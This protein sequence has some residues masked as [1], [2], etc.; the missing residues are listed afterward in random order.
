MEN[1]NFKEHTKESVINTF[2]IKGKKSPSHRLK[3]LLYKFNI[4]EQVCECCGIE[5]IWN[6][7]P[8]SFHLDHIDG[9][10]LNNEVI[11]LRILCPN[12]HSQTDT[13]AGKKNKKTK[14][15]KLIELDRHCPQCDSLITRRA[16]LCNSCSGTKK[17][18]EKRSFVLPTKEELIQMLKDTNFVQV[19]KKYNVS[20]N[21]VKKWCIKYSISSYSK[22]YK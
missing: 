15:Q 19:G 2:L 18:E 8:I 21:A 9:D 17:A 10:N 5:P 20:A 6:G 13:Y 7:K 22:D 1:N 3:L 14:E 4:K 16:T 12:C 11:N